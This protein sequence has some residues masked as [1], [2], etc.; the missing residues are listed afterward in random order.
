MD[1]VVDDRPVEHE[2][3]VGLPDEV[4][5]DGVRPAHAVRDGH[6]HHLHPVALRLLDGLAQV[7]VARDEIHDV[8]HAVA[9]VRREVEPDAQ[10][11]T[12]LLTLR[13][14]PAEA[15]LDPRKHADR[16][17][18]GVRHTSAPTAG[19]VPVDPQQRHPARL[20]GRRR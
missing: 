16:L 12:L 20:L 13:G 11:D 3:V 17:L 18:L 9:P 19:V 6:Q 15:Q 4:L 5:R 10:V 7:V 1:G 14:E 8:D 2:E